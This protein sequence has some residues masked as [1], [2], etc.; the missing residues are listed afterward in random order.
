[1][2]DT[3]KITDGLYCSFCGR[4]NT[5]YDLDIMFAGPDGSDVAICSDCV[6]SLVEIIYDLKRFELEDSNEP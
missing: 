4:H 3:T 6:M 1:M 5:A 2:D